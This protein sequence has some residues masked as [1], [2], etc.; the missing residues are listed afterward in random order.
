[1]GTGLERFYY[2]FAIGLPKYTSVSVIIA[3]TVTLVFFWLSGLKTQVFLSFVA[4]VYALFILRLCS[5]AKI[6]TVRRLLWLLTL[7][8]LA[9][10]GA[11]LL[12][13]DPARVMSIA[14]ILPFFVCLGFNSSPACFLAFGAIIPLYFA[15]KIYVIAYLASLT[16]AGIGL[17]LT[18]FV[19]GG[20]LKPFRIAVAHIRA[21]LADDYSLIEDIFSCEKRRTLS[22]IITY[23]LANGACISIVI[24]G[25]HFGPFRSAGSSR[26]PYE[27]EE[28]CNNNV[29]VLHSVL[30]HSYNV[31]K[32][33]D[34]REYTRLIADTISR[35]C[36][37][38]CSSRHGYES[39]M[40][41]EKKLGEFR[42]MSIPSIL[43]VI[44]VDRP[45]LGIDDIVIWSDGVRYPMVDAHNEVV[46]D[47]RG[48][49]TAK[50][51]EKDI[52][53]LYSQLQMCTDLRVSLVWKRINRVE[54]R[55]L[56]LC[57]PELK[58]LYINCNGSEWAYLI[59][60]S[61]NA[62]YGTRESVERILA[63]N[64]VKGTLLTIDD[65]VCA[66]LEPGVPTREF[67]YDEN[68]GDILKELIE[69]A[70]RIAKSVTGIS[71]EI[72]EKEVIVWGKCYEELLKYMYRGKVA[73][74]IF[75]SSLVIGPLAGLFWP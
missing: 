24:P 67:A 38:A 65:H 9:G 71:Y 43:P 7:G 41:F 58:L 29:V 16:I 55:K 56:G 69:R 8:V 28:N 10:V 11:S 17:L 1:M 74:V 46:I 21:W 40:V 75:L 50:H 6:A 2:R 36:E 35:A 57:K 66:G 26:L 25:V 72:V 51:L 31:S 47:W 44:V 19:F 4:Y 23:K 13:H 15:G 60:P 49:S 52:M 63:S 68:L 61:N 33:K 73:V 14:S 45:G 27:I 32:V 22:H 20:T 39:I 54:A 64:G 18:L 5:G 34:S 70:R 37:L 53:K 59:A 12:S 42:I 30:D 48:L 62:R 3:L